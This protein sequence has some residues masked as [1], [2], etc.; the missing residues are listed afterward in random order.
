[1]STQTFLLYLDIVKKI[2]FRFL[3]VMHQLAVASLLLYHHGNQKF[4]ELLRRLDDDVLLGS[5][6]Y[7]D[8]A[9]GRFY[10]VKLNFNKGD[11]HKETKN[12]KETLS[13]NVSL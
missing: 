5:C 12:S 1:M 8:P 10:L 11:L 13:E 9:T 3:L 7:S 2:K 4:Q 6:V